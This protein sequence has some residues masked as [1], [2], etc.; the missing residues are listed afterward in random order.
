MSFKTTLYAA[1]MPNQMDLKK[2]TSIAHF[3]CKKVNCAQVMQRIN[4]KGD[5]QLMKLQLGI[6]LNNFL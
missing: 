2:N 5:S 3:K 6:Q 1:K 4:I